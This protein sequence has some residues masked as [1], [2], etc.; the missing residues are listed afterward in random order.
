MGW[1]IT[2]YAEKLPKKP[3]KPGTKSSKEKEASL[4]LQYP[5]L[6]GATASAPCIIVDIDGIILA[7]YLPGILSDFRQVGLL[8]LSDRSN[9]PDVF[10]K[11]MLKAREKLRTS[12][13]I[14]KTGSSWRDDI[15]YYHPVG[16]AP[17]GSVNLSTAWFQ[18]GRGVSPSMYKLY[19]S[20]AHSE[21]GNVAR[22]PGGFCELQ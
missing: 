13:K 21:S 2:R 7:W 8:R 19:S 17:V 1:D 22:I 4:R 10:Q 16:A 9:K 15:K 11:A 14:P 12:L 6:N 20:V 18:Q 5:P 3:F